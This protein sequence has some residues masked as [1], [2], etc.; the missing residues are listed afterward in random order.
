MNEVRIDGR[1]IWAR[2]ANLPRGG[3]VTNFA[4]AVAGSRG[5]TTVKCVAWSAD[6]GETEIAKD[7]Y[8]RI[9]SG[10]LEMQRAY[11]EHPEYL[12]VK[13]H[14][15]EEVRHKS[16]RPKSPPP[17]PPVGDPGDDGDIPF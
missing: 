14:S 2:T 11:K 4:L 7:G 6:V 10:E 1:C 13:A 17:E 15:I 16:E 3:S 5:S 8:Y 12:A 9:E